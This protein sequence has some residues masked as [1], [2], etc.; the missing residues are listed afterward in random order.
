MGR[1]KLEK[2]GIKA[3]QEGDFQR[4]LIALREAVAVERP[5]SLAWLWLSRT[6]LA[7]DDSNAALDSILTYLK[8]NPA[9]SPGVLQLVDV[10]CK[11]GERTKAIRL[12]LLL[13]Q[14]HFDEPE[15][16][17][18]IL[19]HLSE[20]DAFH[21]MVVIA[22]RLHALN[23]DDQDHI[24]ALATA[25][26]RTRNFEKADAVIAKAL[27]GDPERAGLAKSRVAL[28]LGMAVAA[29]AALV[30]LADDKVHANHVISVAQHLLQQGHCTLALEAAN[31][32][33]RVATGDT[34]V[35]RK[36]ERIRGEVH[37]LKGGW[38]SPEWESRPIR[39]CLGRVLHVVGASAPHRQTG[40]TVRTQSIVQAQREAGLLPEVVTP[41]GFPWTD[42]AIEAYVRE[43]VGEI[44]HHRLTPFDAADG[45]LYDGET[46]MNAMPVRPDEWLTENARRLAILTRQLQ[47]AVLHAASDYRNA[48][49]TLATGE[50]LGVPVVYEVRGFPWETWLSRNPCHTSGAE[51]YVWHQERE[52][53]CA[54]RANHVVTLAE[55]MREELIGWG[56]AQNKITVIPNAVD[57]EK[58]RPI[59]RNPDLAAS[60]GIGPEETVLGYISSIERLEGIEYLIAATARLHAAGHVVRTLIVGQGTDKPRLEAYAAELGIEGRII[61]A[62]KVPHAD[63]LPYYGLIDIFV[64]PRTNDRV[65]N[66]VTPLKPYE[67]MATERAIIVSAVPALQEMVIP[68]ITGITF[69][70]E[71]PVHLTATIEPLIDDP[72]RRR[73][74]G[75]TAR[76]W[77]CQHRTWAANGQRYCDMYGALGVPMPRDT[78]EAE[79]TSDLLWL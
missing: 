47:P 27:P 77:V 68:G 42:G 34:R 56:V 33:E 66:L 16:L 36:S 78:R 74:L 69:T 6:Q 50:L 60:L 8:S 59:G 45:I 70:P 31:R 7:M 71:D 10:L 25:V 63:I 72:E 15:I 46:V 55:V 73:A 49:P 17:G 76:R 38:R 29:W 57:V 19:S 67:A 37:L 11:Q 13:A 22:R 44:P 39:H 51:S 14:N 23:P 21:E 53:E 24:V 40:Y 41:L 48:L 75:R 79:Q 9:S 62:G 30:P 4:A 2:R 5:R 54:M 52:T 58:F 3:Y 61:F 26:G 20:L 18:V 64:V 65:C 43:E 35:F 12:L 1:A 32:A 28:Q